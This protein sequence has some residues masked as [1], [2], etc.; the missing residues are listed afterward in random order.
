MWIDIITILL[1]AFLSTVALGFIGFAFL[2]II[3]IECDFTQVKSSFVCLLS[4]IVL[5]TVVFAIFITK[6]KTIFVL[7]VLFL[8]LL[9]RKP[10]LNLNSPAPPMFKMVAI[11]VTAFIII[12]G[13][14]VFENIY[15]FETGFR[16]ITP[17]RDAVAYCTISAGIKHAGMESFYNFDA[18]YFDPVY[19]S[20]VPYHFLEL[21]F[22]ALFSLVFQQPAL[23]TYF[24]FTQPIFIFSSLLGIWSLFEKFNPNLK[25]SGYAI[26][27]FSLFFCG[28]VLNNFYFT[29]LWGYLGYSTFSV[30]SYKMAFYFPFFIGAILFALARNYH[31]S[32]LITA[33]CLLLNISFFPA[34]S[35]GV[36]LFIFISCA[37]HRFR[38]W[39]FNRFLMLWIAW[40]LLIVLFY[41]LFPAKVKAEGL[42]VNN[43]IAAFSF[44]T[45]KVYVVDSYIKLA[46][47][48]WP[49]IMIT[50]YTVVVQKLVKKIV[51]NPVFWI[52]FFVVNLGLLA[53]ILNLYFF[54]A[55]QFFTLTTGLVINAIFL[56]FIGYAL[57]SDNWKVRIGTVVIFFICVGLT[58]V[59]Y[60]EI[61]FSKEKNKQVFSPRFLATVKKSI[62]EC[63]VKAGL[64]LC[65]T[66]TLSFRS[67]PFVHEM[68]GKY[69]FLVDDN[70][71]ITPY[72]A[73]V[74]IH[75]VLANET[76]FPKRAPFY[77]FA[78]MHSEKKDSE[79]VSNFLKQKKIGFIVTTEKIKLPDVFNAHVKQIIKAENSD[80]IL[81][82]LKAL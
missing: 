21:H 38:V 45:L 42:S 9:K 51:F 46:L 27:F 66:G 69:L 5:T 71:Y 76:W 30:F 67:L 35:V 75:E 77:Y 8:L 64:F 68:P 25:L 59:N 28:F 7:S 4:G 65:E 73:N 52:A 82:L 6:G 54:N 11:S 22:N 12:I 23:I 44:K 58:F 49:W 15:D 61:A 40:C 47:L 29:E 2:R 31:V 62:D 34:L 63:P 43:I 57:A 19:E 79:I 81:V 50:A 26:G 48:Y 80:E 36:A 74:S 56:A 60:N 55:F 10:A 72:I 20:V 1:K 78:S 41:A 37:Y 53:W 39:E 13:W 16:K 32:F 14:E 3:G 70:I 17:F 33:F 18:F 24:T